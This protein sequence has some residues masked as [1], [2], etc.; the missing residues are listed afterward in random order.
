MAGS[1]W[2]VPLLLTLGLATLVILGVLVALAIMG[3]RELRREVNSRQGELARRAALVESRL[4]R[5]EGQDT[6]SKA[7][8]RGRTR[9]SGTLPKAWRKEPPAASPGGPNLFEPRISPTLIAV[10]ALAAPSPGPDGH[11]EEELGE[12]HLDIL[13]LAAAGASPGEIARQTGQPIG[14]VELILGLHRQIHS[15]RGPADHARAV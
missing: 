4:D 2:F 13:S 9:R 12:R 5:L 1:D 10:P 11:P 6:E 15:S 7:A 8:G 3:L 14:Q